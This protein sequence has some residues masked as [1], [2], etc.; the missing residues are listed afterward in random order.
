MVKLQRLHVRF[1]NTTWRFN[2]LYLVS[3]VVPTA[4]HAVLQR[5]VDGGMPLVWNQNGV[6][7]GG[8]HGPGWEDV[9]AEMA[10]LLRAASHVVYQS[11]FCKLS[12]DRFLG[13]PPGSWDVLYNAVDTAAFTPS[14]PS[15]RGLTLLVG[16]TQD[17]AYRLTIALET[18]ALV[19]RVRSD[20]RMLVTGRLAWKRGA[21][22]AAQEAGAVLRRLGL[23]EHVTFTGSYTQSDAPA[24]YGGA[25][26]LLHCKYN[27]PSPGLVIEAMAC[28]LPVVYSASGGVPEIVGTDAGI[29]VAAPLSWDEEIPPDPETLARAVLAVAERR[30]DFAAA[31]RQRAVDCF[32]IG[33][34]LARHGEIFEALAAKGRR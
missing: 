30:T 14:P 22:T 5:I 16:G 4:G 8:W 9:N 6:A 19:R 31:A 2:V 34:W 33:P 17:V 3:S 25:D 23:E 24:L 21:V 7:Y 12:A 28:G 13:P 1:P 20:A 11:R 29:G 26:L 18:L 27:D 15:R 10:C 32:A